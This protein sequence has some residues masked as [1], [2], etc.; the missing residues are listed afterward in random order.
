MSNPSIPIE[1]QRHMQI[2]KTLDQLVKQVE[3]VAKALEAN[4]LQ[5]GTPDPR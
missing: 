1:Q 5:T 2:L 3:R 4:N